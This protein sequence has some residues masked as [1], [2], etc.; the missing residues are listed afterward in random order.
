MTKFTR[1][2]FVVTGTA[3]TA[4]LATRRAARADAIKVAGVH[5]APVENPWNS[6]LHVA[7]QEAEK[8]GEISYAFSEA[9]SNTDYER[10]MREYAEQGVQLIVGESYGVE[11]AARAAAADYPKVAILMGSSGKPAGGN[12]SVFGTWNHEAAYLT[13]M[14][15][16]R[17]TKSN[18]LGSVGGYPIP[19]VNR[20]INAFRLGAKEVNPNVS[21]KVGFIGTWYD[22]PKAKETAL[23]QIDAG[24]D[25]LFGER[26]GTADAAKEKGVMSI[27]SLIDFTPQFPGTVIANAIWNFDPIVGAAIAD[28]KA[29]NIVA[30]DYSEFSF[31]KHGGNALAYDDKA[32][33]ADVAEA[34]LAKQKEIAAGSFTV[35]VD[36]TEP[37]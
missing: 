8:R 24:A 12:F 3:A 6:R 32:V 19:E 14:I 17:M 37:T 31:M 26:I 30:R 9:V 5:T 10:V 13:G 21:F 34:A 28:V 36:D 11:D 2:S 4:M 20:L 33:P 35:P 22:P 7:M 27:G 15:A 16:G 18:I 23:A 25:I 29:G 1:R